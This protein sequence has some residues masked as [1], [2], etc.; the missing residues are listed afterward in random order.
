MNTSKSLIS[1]FLAIVFSHSLFAKDD[2]FGVGAKV[3]EAIDVHAILSEPEQFMEKELTVAG[4]V[5]SVC[6]KKGCWMM[7]SSGDARLRI[8]VK[9]GEMVFPFNA[10]GK[11]AYATG[12][13][14]K[15]E[16]TQEKAVAYLKHMAE[17]AGETFDPE[18]VKGDV[19][20]YQLRPVGVTIKR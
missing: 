3:A 14:E 19:T 13:L 9:D 12:K 8:K 4:E 15:M 16:M 10:K 7:L 6:D 5:V 18:S 11:T 2:S 1:L 20:L 17:D